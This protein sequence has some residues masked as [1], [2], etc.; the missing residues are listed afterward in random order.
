M[1]WLSVQFP[2]L[3]L[4]IFAAECDGAD[5]SDKERP[6]VLTEN[7][8]VVLCNPAARR[9]GI[10]TGSS[11]ATAQSIC[12]HLQIIERNSDQ[13]QKHLE[14]LAEH[15]YGYSSRVSITEPSG[16]RREVG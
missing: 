1:L 5:G 13:E 2:S 16:L 14:A 3:G 4:E 8:K 7:G 10:R 12:T 6:R 9:T 15:A 11:N